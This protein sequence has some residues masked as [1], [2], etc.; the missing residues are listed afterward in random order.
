MEQAMASVRA[1]NAA[2]D[3][4]WASNLVEAVVKTKD[5]MSTVRS[6]EG[7]KPVMKPPPTWPRSPRE[8]IKPF[9]SSPYR[10]DDDE[11]PEHWETATAAAAQQ[12]ATVIAQAKERAFPSQPKS[13]PGPKGF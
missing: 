8:Q 7:P 1:K 5:A 3:A 13:K 12:A 4:E 11:P 10:S 6:A 9:F 2:E